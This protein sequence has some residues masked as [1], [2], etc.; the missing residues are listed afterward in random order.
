[1]TVIIVFSLSILVA[2]VFAFVVLWGSDE[3]E[4]EEIESPHRGWEDAPHS[5]DQPSD[6]F[7]LVPPR[8]EDP[9]ET[10]AHH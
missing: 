7:L 4:K 10:T 3:G 6:P 8:R 2:V 5:V 1:M 9:Q